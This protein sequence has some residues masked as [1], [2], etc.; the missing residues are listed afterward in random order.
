MGRDRELEQRIQG[1]EWQEFERLVYDLVHAEHPEAYRQTPPDCGA[2]V[3]VPDSG[4]GGP[5]VF[6]VKHY[7]RSKAAV[8]KCED[9][10]RAALNLRPASI[11]F[12]FSHDLSAKRR[13]T[14]EMALVE[15]FPHIEV[16]FWTLSKLRA[17]LNKH[18]TVR[19]DHFAGTVAGTPTDIEALAR[20]VNMQTRIDRLFSMGAAAGEDDPNFSY[21]IFYSEGH[22]PPPLMQEPAVRIDLQRDGRYLRLAAHRRAGRPGV[23]GVWCFTDDDAGAAAKYEALRAVSRGDH[24]VAVESG[25][26]TKLTTPQSV[27][28]RR[29][30]LSHQSSAGKRAFASHPDR[31]YHSRSSPTE[32]N[33]SSATSPSIRSHRSTGSTAAISDWTGL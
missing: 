22:P 8:R 3:V 33:A 18:P 16:R 14:L 4:G 23:T 6:Q 28:R 1:L 15:P 5:A 25:I 31:E 9:S 13:R 12:V 26:E 11:T 21:E 19:D 7:P 27:S 2:D 30:R 24:E 10:L 29:C 17:L 20:A 32:I